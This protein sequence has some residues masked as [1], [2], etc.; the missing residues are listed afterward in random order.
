MR[1]TGWW[2]KGRLLVVSGLIGVSI[3][4]CP[5]AVT[6]ND[7]AGTTGDSAADSGRTPTTTTGGGATGGGGTPT[8]TGD[9][10]PT[11]P[12]TPIVNAGP[13]QSVEDGD[14]VT[15]S[16]NATDA[17]GPVTLSWVQ[18]SG[19]AVPLT[20][21]N[22]ATATF[23]APIASGDMVFEL[24]ATSASG[25]VATD[26]VTVSVAAAPLLFV[27]NQGGGGSVASF[28]MNK[29]ADGNL[30]PRTL[31]TG[32]N[33][34][35]QTPTGVL[36]DGKGSL[37]VT[38]A[39]GNRLG[40]FANGLI[41]TGDT[42]PDR[43]VTNPGAELVFP[44]A[45]AQDPV[46]DELY[47]ANF[48]GIPAVVNV[49]G[50]ASQPSFSGRIPPDR[51]IQSNSMRNPSAIRL[52]GGSLYVSNAGSHTIAVFDNAAAINGE[53][54]A[55]RLISGDDLQASTPVDFAVDA[56]DRLIVLNGNEK[57]VL[58]FDKAST[59]NGDVTPRAVLTLRGASQLRGIAVDARGAAYITDYAASKI[60]VVGNIGG[61][62]TATIDADRTLTG[63]ATQINAPFHM[64]LVER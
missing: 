56:Q 58:V 25:G 44:Q 16:G 11:T 2:S 51:R 13:D 5:K 24:T 4:G 23:T 50:A 35:L 20:G 62:A 21:A 30:A 22:A 49:Y 42:N 28:R 9:P 6:D 53:V 43:F 31:L 8:T 34:R 33:T 3:A 57:T 29:A 19:A 54:T 39:D 41:V 12:T 37:F 40:G 59:I 61:R 1:N 15:L 47:V 45:L 32:A 14:A 48:D 64:F 38:S 27:T 55:S 7:T 52:I 10:K 26:R 60:Y 46:R 18:I 36:I 63:D 17:G